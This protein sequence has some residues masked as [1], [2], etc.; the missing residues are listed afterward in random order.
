M[1]IGSVWEQILDNVEMTVQSRFVQG[2]LITALSAFDAHRRNRY[3][4]LLPDLL[5]LALRRSFRRLS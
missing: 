5:R 2:S 1:H 3:P 4:L